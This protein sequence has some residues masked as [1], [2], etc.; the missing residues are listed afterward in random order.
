VNQADVV[1]WEER[2]MSE[3][4]LSQLQQEA[5][6][7]AVARGQWPRGCRATA[8][9][10]SVLAT[11]ARRALGEEVTELGAALSRLGASG[12]L[13]PVAD[14]L[15]DVVIVCASISEALGIDLERAVRAKMRRNEERAREHARAKRQREVEAM[16]DRL[17]PDRLTELRRIAE[18]ATP[19][20]WRLR[21]D[22]RYDDVPPDRFVIA[23][24]E[25]AHI[26]ETTQGGSWTD[27]DLA[28]ARYISTFDPPTVL[29]LLDEI[30]SLRRKLVDASDALIWMGNKVTEALH[31]L[32]S[33]PGSENNPKGALDILYAAYRRYHDELKGRVTNCE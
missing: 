2:P 29:S 33:E 11:V 17:T 23:S 12:P 7:V 32:T 9:V 30:E 24:D 21:T 3:L 22:P 8:A 20:P 18:A 1:E 13:D 27:E 25:R 31:A 5:Y 14:E 15:A 26:V 4:T 19:G 16:V 6:R 28:N 10:P